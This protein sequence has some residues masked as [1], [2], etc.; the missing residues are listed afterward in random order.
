[1][2]RQKIGRVSYMWIGGRRIKLVKR[3]NGWWWRVETWL[4]GFPSKGPFST[5]ALACQH[6][7]DYC[8]SGI[9]VFPS[10]HR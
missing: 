9:R 10:R 4:V 3:K 2:S 7:A 5:W 1:M 6:A 8:M